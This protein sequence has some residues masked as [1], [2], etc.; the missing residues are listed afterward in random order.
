[1]GL[2][3]GRIHVSL[4]FPQSTAEIRLKMLSDR[5]IKGV[6]EF[7]SRHGTIGPPHGCGPRFHVSDLEAYEIS[8]LHV[9]ELCDNTATFARDICHDN[10]K[11]CASGEAYGCLG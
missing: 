6:G 7:E 8:G 1:M 5:P 2:R 11:F 9:Q 4:C 10:L 3:Y